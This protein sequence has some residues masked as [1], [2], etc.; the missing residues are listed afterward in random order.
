MND[1]D[2]LKLLKNYI[3]SSTSSNEYETLIEKI[4]SNIH[5]ELFI[6]N[7]RNHPLAIKLLA[8]NIES[9]QNFELF[10]ENLQRLKSI[11]DNEEF[12]AKLIFSIY[13]NTNLQ[14]LEKWILLQLS[15][16]PNDIT[17]DNFASLL[18]LHS[19]EEI[20]TTATVGFDNYLMFNSGEYDSNSTLNEI[21]KNLNSKAWIE[22]KEDFI[23]IPD[24][25]RETIKEN[26]K[27]I[28]DYYFEI[29]ETLHIEFFETEYG[30]FN[31]DM[32]YAN[33]LERLIL[34][35]DFE[36][37]NDDTSNLIK[38]L[39]DTYRSIYQLRSELRVQKYYTELIE[40]KTGANSEETGWS[41]FDLAKCF[42]RNGIYKD[43][44]VNVLKSHDILSLHQL[45]M[46]EKVSL[47]NIVGY[48]Y[49][50][51]RNYEKSLEYG[52]KELSILEK[53]GYK[54]PSLA[55]AY[56][57][58]AV[59]YAEM[60]NLE[61]NIEYGLKNLHVMESI[62]EEDDPALGTIYH[63]I[64]QTYRELKNDDEYVN[65]EVKHVRI[66][67][68]QIDN[69]SPELGES[70][71]FLASTYWEKQR[72]PNAKFYIEQSVKILSKVL[73]EDHPVLVKA[74]NLKQEIK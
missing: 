22:I 29:F 45:E 73:P 16:I 60:G 42:E 8:S 23:Q 61:K 49:H 53:L 30:I 4:K 24:L 28:P 41:Y 48:I 50:K 3:S 19:K 54:I 66:M 25:I 38:K 37:H 34:I 5:L 55:T 71:F 63:N 21:L 47:Y 51:N 43:A 10:V 14:H 57:N 18:Q 12:L 56:N 9:F 13:D 70:Y 2:S 1:E 26:E 6:A 62:L 33:F 74:L 59:A 11:E 15:A 58:V 64:A 7:L 17:V 39:I 72:K 31:S 46:N 68:K 35:F 27:L 40:Y 65:Y 36:F 32:L 52:L 67:E 69:V 20:I 44:L